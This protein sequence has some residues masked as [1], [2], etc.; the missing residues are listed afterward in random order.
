M[1]ICPECGADMD[2]KNPCPDCGHEI[3]APKPSVDG[4][5]PPKVEEEDL[6]P[7]EGKDG[8]GAKGKKAKVDGESV[9]TTRIDYWG[10][11]NASA[12]MS[13]PL[14]KTESGSLTGK[15]AIFGVGV[16]R[17]MGA[18]GKVTSEF[19]PPEEVFSEE[20]LDSYELVPLTN[21]H[22]PEK[23][24]PENYKKY[25]VGNLGEEIENDAYNA[26][27]ELVIHDATAI[28][29]VEA[30]RT[31][32]SGG[33]SCN[34][35]TSGTVKYPIMGWNDDYTEKVVKAYTTYNVPGNFNGTP[36]DAIQ[37]Q[38]R[39]NHVA[40]VDI[41]RGGDA[42]HMRFD[43]DDVGVG[44]RVP[45]TQTTPTQT[46]ETE[47]M[48][49]IKLDGQTQEH[50]VPEAVA[51]HIDGLEASVA[52]LTKEKA[53][54]ESKVAAANAAVEAMK[55]DADNL[56]ASIPAKVQEGISARL[57]L[58]AKVDGLKVEVKH[59]DSEETIKAAVVKAAMP[60][61]NLD[62]ADATKLDAYFEAA[63]TVLG[64]RHADSGAHA[65][66]Q[67]LHGDGVKPEDKVDGSDWGAYQDSLRK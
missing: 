43:G 63:C 6:K 19:R 50:E 16:Y 56:K 42:L 65:Q 32:L 18:D 55:A 11:L 25:A 54:A 13:E 62:G 15:A 5:K 31:G 33:Y 2:P 26:Y 12:T 45:G 47:S 53:D 41:P 4:I 35:V 39:G 51:I 17:Y 14:T 58:V 64:G 10:D 46:K 38:I 30:G 49:K 8:C 29:A 44:I 66:L 48:K 9:A 36:Y 67:Q 60:N 61:V 28:A 52:N 57:A 1:S 24:T 40:I 23:V 37:T 7:N 27:A 20:T 21:N 22:P 3:G 59:E 34:V